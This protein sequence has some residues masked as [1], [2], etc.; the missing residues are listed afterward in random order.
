MD[1]KQSLDANDVEKYNIKVEA[2]YY[3]YK[4]P[5]CKKCCTCSCS[6]GCDSMTCCVGS[7]SADEQWSQLVTASTFY[8][9][10]NSPACLSATITAQPHTS[11]ST[12]VG[13]AYTQNGASWYD[14][15]S[16]STTDNHCGPFTVELDQS[17]SSSPTGNSLTFSQINYSLD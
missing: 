6:A 2:R 16:G 3:Y 15:V 11:F 4:A 13:V 17:Q 10:L 8:T 12:T 9:Y 7:Y 1:F 5:Y 14:S